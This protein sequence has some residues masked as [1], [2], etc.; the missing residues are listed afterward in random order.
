MV[1]RVTLTNGHYFKCQDPRSDFHI[2]F[3]IDRSSSMKASDRKPLP[4]VPVEV[5]LSAKHNN[6]LGAVYDT[7]IHTRHSTLRNRV[8]VSAAA[9]SNDTLSLVLFASRATIVITNRKL[10]GSGGLIKEMIKHHASM[11]LI[12][13]I[14]KH[15]TLRGTDFAPVI[16]QATRKS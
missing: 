6:R 7:V 9:L 3:V 2:I 11:G 13:D 8:G 5:K 16:T 10:G 1:P 15:F 14:R 12:E 4:N